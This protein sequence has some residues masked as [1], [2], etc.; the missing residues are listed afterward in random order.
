MLEGAVP[1]M[2]LSLLIT[3]SHNSCTLNMLM[4]FIVMIVM[5]VMMIINMFNSCTLRMTMIVMAGEEVSFEEMSEQLILFCEIIQHLHVDHNT[6]DDNDNYND[7]DGDDDDNVGCEAD[8]DDDD[9]NR[10]LVAAGFDDICGVIT[11]CSKA[12][13]RANDIAA[14]CELELLRLNS[15][16]TNDIIPVNFFG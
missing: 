15:A 13:C 12:G 9:D 3:A 16:D 4:I 5:I 10:T 7:D 1:V 14:L 2:Y 6:D 8:D 11:E